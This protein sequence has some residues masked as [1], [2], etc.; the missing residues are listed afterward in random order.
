MVLR[1]TVECPGAVDAPWWD[2]ALLGSLVG[3][4][5][6]GLIALGVFFL[7]RKHERELAVKDREERERVMNHE[8]ALTSV[9]ELERALYDLNQNIPGWLTGAWHPARQRLGQVVL[10]EVPFLIKV[11]PQA[12]N[13]VIKVGTWIGQ[14]MPERF[15]AE[16]KSTES[17]QRL[18]VEARARITIATRMLT[19]FRLG[20]MNHP[21][22]D[23]AKE[24]AEVV[25]FEVARS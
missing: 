22:G 2:S 15:A 23:L 12:A 21:P 4:L 8:R 5:L 24:M 18:A 9:L 1:A 13:E 7:T 11:D 10:R 17:A 25:A 6:T 3:A 20:E 19:G 14:E 16:G